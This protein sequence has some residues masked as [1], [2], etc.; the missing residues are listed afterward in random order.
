M[1]IDVKLE[2]QKMMEREKK[3]RKPIRGRGKK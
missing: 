3:K 1:A 2:I